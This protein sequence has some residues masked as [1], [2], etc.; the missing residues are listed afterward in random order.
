ML[1]EGKR[2]NKVTRDDFAGYRTPRKVARLYLE[3]KLKE[4]QF[5]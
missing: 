3:V 4:A 5:S 1:F 2:I